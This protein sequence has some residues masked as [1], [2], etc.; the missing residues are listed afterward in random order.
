[1]GVMGITPKL[2]QFVVAW[3]SVAPTRFVLADT[4]RLTRGAR[5]P[6]SER[7]TGVSDHQIRSGN[8]WVVNSLETLAT[9]GVERPVSSV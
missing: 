9:R 3:G 1:M 6:W 2:E 8:P 5:N 7:D 4:A